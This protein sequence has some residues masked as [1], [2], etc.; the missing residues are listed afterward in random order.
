MYGEGGTGKSQVIKAIIE[1]FFKN[2]F[3]NQLLVSAPTGSAAS[4]IHGNIILNFLY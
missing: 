1:I 4:L 2:N 3:L